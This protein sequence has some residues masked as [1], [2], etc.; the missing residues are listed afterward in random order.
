MKRIDNMHKDKTELQRMSLLGFI[1]MRL[2]LLDELSEKLNV[3]ATLKGREMRDELV[4]R[5]M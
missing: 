5:S 1:L 2:D 4:Q 3:I